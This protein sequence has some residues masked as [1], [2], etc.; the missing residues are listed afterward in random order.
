MTN[1][2]Q[3]NLL[4]KLV[5]NK[6]FWAISC[7]ILFGFPVYKSVNRILP[8][9]LPILAKVPEFRFVDEDGK[10]FGTREL[11]GKVYIA[12]FMFTTCQTSCPTLLAKVQNV[13]HR[14][15]GVIDR[16]AIVS[17]TVDPET[18]TSAVLYAKAREMKANPAVW[19]F[20]SASVAETKKLLVEGFKVPVGDKE[21]ANNVMDV[22]HSNKLVLVDQDENI[23]GY[24][25]TDKDSINQLMIDAGL[26]INKKKQ[27]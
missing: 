18:D 11:Q 24:Y 12:N 10:T 20:L 17:F 23:R 2:R 3:T 21:I 6:W 19:K 9:D 7:A 8:P 4:E 16:A 22:G 1:V 27:S 14:L 25:N 15:R 5:L 26:I 13:Q